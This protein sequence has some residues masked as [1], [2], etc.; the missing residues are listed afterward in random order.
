MN[1]CEVLAAGACRV[2]VGAAVTAS[3]DPRGMAA[4]LR[5][6]LSLI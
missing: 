3:E 4:R 5:S 2:A 6:M 1:V